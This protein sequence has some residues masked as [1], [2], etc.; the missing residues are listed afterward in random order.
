VWELV[1][2][3]RERQQHARHLLAVVRLLDVGE[4]AAAATACRLRI[5]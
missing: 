5:T 2:V 3:K 1:K 4:A